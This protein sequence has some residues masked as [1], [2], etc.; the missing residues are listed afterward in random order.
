MEF[1]DSNN[2]LDAMMRTSPDIEAFALEIAEQGADRWTLR[3]RWRTGFNATHVRAEVGRDA[4]GY[5]E[6]ITDAWG[7]YAEY[8]ERGT[9]WNRPEHVMRD[10]IRDVEG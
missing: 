8:R 9:R 3:S 10:F 1:D 5:I 2:N 7:Y 4:D 6:G